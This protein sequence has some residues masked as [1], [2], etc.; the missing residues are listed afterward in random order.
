MK[1]IGMIEIEKLTFEKK[2]NL[3]ALLRHHPIDFFMKIK[4][5]SMNGL[6]KRHTEFNCDPT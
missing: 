5:E 6:S 4:C 3:T 1:Y 2:K